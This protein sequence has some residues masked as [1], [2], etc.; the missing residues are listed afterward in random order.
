VA[1]QTKGAALINNTSQHGSHTFWA[2]VSKNG[3]PYAIGP[4]SVLFLRD[5]VVLWSNGWTDPDETWRAAIGLGHGNSVL[6]VDCRSPSP[7]GHSPQFSDHICCMA[8][9]L[10]GSR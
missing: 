2:T 9:W 8:K 4:L 10:D 1:I 5:V 3:S 6:D 7:K